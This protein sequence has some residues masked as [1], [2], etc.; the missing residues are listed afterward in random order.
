MAIYH[1]PNRIQRLLNNGKIDKYGELG[2]DVVYLD[3]DVPTVSNDS[4]TLPYN[5]NDF[6][7]TVVVRYPQGSEVETTTVDAD[8]VEETG[9]T[10]EVVAGNF[11]ERT[12]TFR[13]TSQNTSEEDRE[14]SI[15][16]TFKQFDMALSIN[17]TQQRVPRLFEA[18][19]HATP[20]VG[21]A[22]TFI[23]NTSGLTVANGGGS[24]WLHIV[25][26]SGASWSV[27][28]PSWAS[29]GTST[30]AST[31]SLSGTLT[32]TTGQNPPIPGGSDGISVIEIVI[33]DE[34][35][36]GVARLLD[37]NTVTI[38]N[39]NV[40][41]GQTG[42]TQSTSNIVT[43]VGSI[44]PT[45]N[46]VTLPAGSTVFPY[47]KFTFTGGLTGGVAPFNYEIA[48]N[49]GFT[50]YV[51]DYDTGTV[52]NGT[53]AAAGITSRSFSIVD[54]IG[55]ATTY[56]VRITDSNNDVVTATSGNLG[57]YDMT[58]GTS[59]VFLLSF[60]N[61]SGAFALG[62]T[63]NTPAGSAGWNL[64]N[65]ESEEASVDGAPDFI[66][67]FGV[68]Y[69]FNSGTITLNNV[70]WTENASLHDR[71]NNINIYYVYTDPLTEASTPIS[72]APTR[73]LGGNIGVYQY[74]RP[75]IPMGIKG[76]LSE[77]GW[78][79]DSETIFTV[80]HDKDQ[81]PLTVLNSTASWI[82]TREQ[83]PVN[84][85]IV[86]QT[87]PD[88]TNTVRAKLSDADIATYIT[89][90]YISEVSFL[91]TSGST[92][93]LEQLTDDQLASWKENAYETRITFRTLD[94]GEDVPDAPSGD[95]SVRQGQSPGEQSRSDG[96]DFVCANSTQA[97]GTVNGYPDNISFH[98]I[99]NLK[100]STGAGSTAQAAHTSN[101]GGTLRID[102]NVVSK[103]TYAVANA[104][105]SPFSGW[106]SFREGNGAGF[107]AVDAAV[108]FSNG[109][110]VAVEDDFS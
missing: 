70:V 46:E 90:D 79:A 104:T 107:T 20:N 82:D 74:A 11:L 108:Q 99:S 38:T 5:I 18:T 56:Y 9:F 80:I 60:L 84:I 40:T 109:K 54:S 48:T 86:N 45:A 8:F 91:S 106:V 88:T 67:S 4:F 96:V 24:V 65:I 93:S 52:W 83:S 42:R 31:H 19:Y 34:G 102:S 23:G 1:G 98:T 103:M 57:V 37:S 92:G 89:S 71:Q 100:Y 21:G 28:L 13:I 12:F 64:S 26:D 7:Y 81:Y 69:G 16:F 47:R 62:T 58:W 3:T 68:S 44:A 78:Q 35:Q 53:G 30:P 33:A 39:T 61:T 87:T 101:S 32:F 51:T 36:S 94:P 43:Q 66:T 22:G 95:T 25:G 49:S 6:D 73:H 85:D 10:E 27:T 17:L 50:S 55:S 59:Q 110:A 105:G 72:T 63:G 2:G 77:F 76:D 14:G 15:T 97:D 75:A 41:A 29:L